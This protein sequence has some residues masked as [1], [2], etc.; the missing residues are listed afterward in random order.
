M[1]EERLVE[2]TGNLSSHM[3]VPW[4]AKGFCQSEAVF[5]LNFKSMSR[6]DVR[7]FG[8]R[9]LFQEATVTIVSSKDPTRCAIM[10]ILSLDMIAERKQGWLNL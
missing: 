8:E 6:I 10:Y 1:D 3:A 7:L 9:R 2:V 4:N 5:S